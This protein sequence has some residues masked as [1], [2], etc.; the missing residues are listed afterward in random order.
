MDVDD[1]RDDEESDDDKG[2][3]RS[4]EVL[5]LLFESIR[6]KVQGRRRERLERA[7][8]DLR[9]RLDQNAGRLL[10]DPELA[11]LALEQQLH[12]VGAVARVASA[13][14]VLLLLPIFLREPQWHG[15]DAEDRRLRIQLALTLARSAVRLPELVQYAW[16]CAMW[17]VEAAVER[18]RLDLRRQREAHDVR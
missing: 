9:G 7:E 2:V 16:G 17:D 1:D 11:L 12:P 3:R 5:Q 8:V 14:V 10:T 15:R 18:A 4:D 6:R 13:D